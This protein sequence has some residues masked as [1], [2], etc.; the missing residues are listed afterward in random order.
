MVDFNV[1]PDGA[2]AAP[3]EG[4]DDAVMAY[5]TNMPRRYDSDDS[6][7]HVEFYKH[8]VTGMDHIKFFFPGDKLFQ[9]D[10]HVTDEYKARFPR[11]WEAYQKQ[12]SQ[13]EGQTLLNDIA[14]LDEASRNNLKAHNVFTLEQLAGMSDTGVDALGMGA[15]KM[16]EK[17]IE[18]LEG[19]KAAAEGNQLR[20]LIAA[21]QAQ[22]EAMQAKLDS[23]ESGRGRGRPRK[24]AE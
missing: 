11:Q 14:W 13:F 1:A 5:Q 6:G 15:R 16:R 23:M 8:P 18:M 7:T 2:E 17:A 10:Y 24:D 3:T 20:E 22:M 12:S 19:Q 4:L 21:Q 9:P